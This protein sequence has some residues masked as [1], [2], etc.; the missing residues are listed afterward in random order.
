MYIT[1]VILSYIRLFSS[2]KGEIWKPMW[3]QWAQYRMTTHICVYIYIYTYMGHVKWR[4]LVG[5]D[6]WLFSQYYVICNSLS[7]FQ[8]TASDPKVPVYGSNQNNSTFCSHSI[9]ETCFWWGI[10]FLFI[11]RWQSIILR[12]ERPLC[13]SLVYIYDLLRL[14]I[15]N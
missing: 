12:T 9:H 6:K 2:L 8:L 11:D 13:F 15:W 7:M 3:C 1:W 10:E 14:Y 4:Y 5:M